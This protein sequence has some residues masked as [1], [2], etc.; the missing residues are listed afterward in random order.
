MSTYASQ[1][2]EEQRAVS[3]AYNRLDALREE[4]KHRLDAV[5]AAGAEPRCRFNAPG[6]GHDA[7][8]AHDHMQPLC[9]VYAPYIGGA[10]VHAA[11]RHH[12]M[13]RNHGQ[14]CLLCTEMPSSGDA[15]GRN[16]D[17][18]GKVGHSV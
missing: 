17:R 1:L 13:R 11:R 7:A 16:G 8:A 15:V 6:H 2:E 10:V 14:V 12:P 4:T 5:R 3:R 18:W 9:A